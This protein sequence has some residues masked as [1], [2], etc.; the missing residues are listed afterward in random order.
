MRLTDRSPRI[1]FL[2]AIGGLALVLAAC[3][4]SGSSTAASAAAPSAAAPSA[5]A[6]AGASAAAGG[7]L[8]LATSSGPVGTYLTGADG[9]TLYVFTKDSPNKSVCV[10]ACAAKWPPVIVSGAAPAAPSGVTGAL[11]TFARPDGSMQLAINGLP[12]YYYAPDTKAG[13]TTGQGVGGVW[14]IATPDGTLP[15][16]APSASR[17]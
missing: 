2:T 10:D 9:K 13:D 14:F 12:L 1:G 8:T 11:T 15:S 16:A 5:A 7:N 17:Y 4:S 6:S 3:S